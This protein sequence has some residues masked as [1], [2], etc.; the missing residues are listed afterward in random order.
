MKVIDARSVLSGPKF[1]TADN[2]PVSTVFYG[3]MAS[4]ESP[5]RL[6]FRVDNSCTLVA[7]DNER[8]AWTQSSAIR[9]YDY[10]PVDITI[11]VN[12]NL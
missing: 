1:I 2:I 8:S 9:V 5:V 3:R 11:T 7:L 4:P 10:Q 6:I 12:K